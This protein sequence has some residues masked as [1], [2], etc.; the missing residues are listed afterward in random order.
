VSPKVTS[1]YDR[2]FKPSRGKEAVD[3][4]FIPVRVEEIDVKK[5]DF[6]SN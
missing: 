2:E 5:F 1:G 4:R 6:L 3:V